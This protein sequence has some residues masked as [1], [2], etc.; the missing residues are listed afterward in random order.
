M[1]GLEPA[2]LRLAHV[3]DVHVTAPA[4]WRLEDW[5]NKRFAAWVNLRVLGRGFRLFRRAD[6]VLAALRRD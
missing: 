5:L 6:E 4:A 3:S 1:A 2:P